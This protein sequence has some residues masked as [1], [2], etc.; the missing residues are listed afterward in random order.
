MTPARLSSPGAERPRRDPLRARGP[1]R[2]GLYRACGVTGAR[3]GGH[4]E[5]SGD[6]AQPDGRADARAA[7]EDSALGVAVLDQPA[8]LSRLVGIV[9]PDCI[10][11]DTQVERLVSERIEL[12]EDDVA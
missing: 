1:G 9:D 12:R 10:G 4:Q 7:D 11:V 8:Q 6:E 2:P 3:P 5:A